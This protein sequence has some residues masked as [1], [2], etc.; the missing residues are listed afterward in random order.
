MEEAHR[1]EFFQAVRLLER[2]FDLTQD[3]RPPQIDQA[4]RH[5]GQIS[6]A[7]PPTE[8]VG[9]RVPEEGRW[10]VE[11]ESALMSLAGA[12]GPLELPFTE[13]V[14]ERV[15]AGDT[16]MQDFLN[17]F[18][19]RLLAML[20]QIRAAHRTG[21]SIQA[22]EHDILS[23]YLF[24]VMGLGTPKVRERLSIPDRSL[25]GGVGLLA[26]EPRSLAGLEALLSAHFGVPV[27]T[28][29]LVG[30]WCPLDATQHTRIGPA[31]QNRRLGDDATLGVAAWD[32][33]RGF[34]V[35]LGPMSWRR[36]NQFLP[37]RTA[38]DAPT[39]AVPT[40]YTALGELTRL[41]CGVFSHFCVRLRLEEGC[42]PPLRLGS[43]EGPRLG[44]TAWAGRPGPDVE[45]KLFGYW[46]SPR[47]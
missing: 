6:L 18:Q 32:Q 23:G 45:V 9:V 7:F 4:I 24:A 26:R 22:P 14:L 44:W 29:P 36:F 42:A 19:H 37:V 39:E 43:P 11:L 30:G 15:Q 27:R 13:L 17:V 21:F 3:R 47:T 5:K 28:R 12:H 16:A 31:G 20:P 2:F 40:A 38:A 8:V 34:D 1:F 10:L 25:L 35:T 46:R 41:Y 33:Q